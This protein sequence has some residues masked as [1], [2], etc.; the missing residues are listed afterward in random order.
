MHPTLLPS[1]DDLL[2]KCDS[3]NVEIVLP[4]SLEPRRLCIVGEALGAEEL[5]KRL[6]FEGKS[7]K[8]LDKLLREVGL[9]RG[10]LH[11]TNVI[12]IQPPG[13]DL[14]RLSELGLELDDFIPYLKEELNHVKPRVILAVG[15]LAMEVLTG[16]FGITK[17]RGSVVDCTFVH[18]DPNPSVV[19][20]L[21]PAYL[22][23]GQMHLYPYVR[24]D[25]KLFAELGFGIHKTHKPFELVV[26]PTFTNTIEYLDSCID[27]AD[28]TCFDIE[29][30]NNER[31][32]CVG[33]SRSPDSAICIPFRYKGLRNRWQKHEFMMILDKIR[34]LYN[35]PLCTKI[36]QN[37]H[38]DMHF[39]LPLLGFPREPLFDTMLAHSL[40]HP[41]AKHDLG[42]IMS[43]YTDMPFHKDE[44]KDWRAQHLP[45]DLTLW[46]YNAKDVIG[47][48]RAYVNL[49]R[50]LIEMNL[51]NFFTG[52]II[53]FRRVLFEMEWRGIKID[54][55]ERQRL[56]ERVETEELPDILWQIEE[57]TGQALNPNSSLQ[58]GGY[59]NEVLKIPV[60]RTEKGNYTVKEDI[61]HELAARYPKH[62]RIIDKIL[63]A[64]VLKAKDLGTYLTAKVSPDGRM[65]TSF[66]T[67]VT[68]RLSSRANM[69][70]EGCLL[71]ETEVLT[72]TG[73][74]R[75]DQ[76][77][78]SD[79]VL[80]Y[81]LNGTLNWC[82]AR[83]YTTYYDGAIVIANAIFHKN[84]YTKNHKVLTTHPTHR[85]TLESK[86]L[87]LI[88]SLNMR[89]LPISG[90]YIGGEE[91]PQYI[92]I[93][94]AIRADGSVENGIIRFAAKKQHKINRFIL[95]ATEL[96]LTLSP[97][98][99]QP[100]Y[101]RFGIS[102]QESAPIV[103]FMEEC[104]WEIGSWILTLS[105]TSLKELIDETK[106]WDA[107][108][109]R[110]SWWFFT[111]D[112]NTAHWVQ[113]GAHL[114]G[115]SAT[116]RWNDY[117]DRGYGKG[118]AKPLWTVAIKPRAYTY[119]ESKHYK[120]SG[121]SG[122]V[123][124]MTTDSGYFLCK[125]KDTIVVTGNT[126]LQN[127]P[128]KFRKLYVPNNGHV[129]LEP[130]LSQAEARVMAWLMKSDKLKTIFRSGQKIHKI[131]GGE[132]YG[133]DPEKLTDDEY[134]IAK[135]TVH[136]S[137]YDMGERKFA[138]LIQKPV[139]L[140]REIRTKYFLIVP[141]LAHYHQRIR[142]TINT[143]RKLTTP[144]GRVRVF[145]GRL[146]DETYR[147][148]YAQIPQ[149]T[150]VDTLNVGTLG[151]WLIKPTNILVLT[152]NHD[153]ILLSMPPSLVEWFKPYIKAH[154]ETLRELTIEG[155]L[156]II[157]V[158]I[159]KAKTN[160][161]GK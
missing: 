160:W 138:T 53:P 93:A 3:N 119:T 41:D 113:T 67:T 109:R 25:V 15:R 83:P 121:Y 126:N 4:E 61:L 7:G 130:D 86:A 89:E 76:L 16:K 116:I 64:R 71:P 98:N 152:Q 1:Y 66:G 70:G 155:D 35:K 49:K 84:T 52:Y 74:T 82:L 85:T 17:W 105:L 148:G 150:V 80:Q 78:K 34:T 141:E 104:N 103:K 97:Q 147:S 43:I 144:Y 44:A 5:L 13:N 90:D 161:L 107:H 122:Q 63:C 117:S 47:T 158:D 100:G 14:A 11:V 77:A 62:K 39:L 65:R 37:M 154:L 46:E 156:L 110:R 31:I 142:E 2:W 137:N 75:L 45:H 153:S 99:A 60:R 139:L 136:G 157:P 118:V 134:L 59:L 127:Q 95:L 54:M 40:I 8:L 6:Y 26:D 29:T 108:I 131:M 56:I 111:T 72:T 57:L 18:Y 68:G 143:D 32:T 145:T 20:T 9:I 124:C 69:F 146:D 58:V 38:Y 73:W 42:F 149:S 28:E 36:G 33:F 87:D 23:R 120:L 22:Q 79:V 135:K 19:P 133:K 48:H 50:D 81:N 10:A 112:Q 21:H 96:G 27:A 92:R 159:G 123:Y 12:K 115:Y 101:R 88:T 128:K 102:K 114:C 94:E 125:H 132:I 24:H 106:Y 140:A 91:N 129:F 30:V 51:Y 55:T 151:L